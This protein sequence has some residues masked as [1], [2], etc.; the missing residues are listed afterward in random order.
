M[1]PRFA[2]AIALALVLEATVT[3]TSRLFPGLGGGYGAPIPVGRVSPLLGQSYREGLVAFDPWILVVN[4][5]LTAAVIL[6]LLPFAKVLGTVAAGF[7]GGLLAYG[8]W[9]GVLDPG[10][11][12]RSLGYPVQEGGVLHPFA[13]WVILVLATLSGILLGR[14]RGPGSVTWTYGAPKVRRAVLA[15]A[16]AAFLQALVTWTSMLLPARD[17]SFNSIYGA[18][19]PVGE[20]SGLYCLACGAGTFN[21]PPLLANILITAALVFLATP[22]PRTWSTGIVGMVG[23]AGGCAIFIATV[24][25]GYSGIEIGFRGFPIPMPAGEQALPWFLWAN[26][27]VWTVVGMALWRRRLPRRIGSLPEPQPRSSRDAST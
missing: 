18:P 5:V 7:L 25:L 6:P 16:S 21:W 1:V 26:L 27:V 8:G 14:L 13:L 9:L 24:V 12:Y 22:A 2:G 23:A 11:S 15:L 3:M 19:I 4:L 10:A 17:W 20:S